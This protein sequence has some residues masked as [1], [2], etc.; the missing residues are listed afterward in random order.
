VNRRQL[1]IGA[2]ATAAAPALSSPAAAQTSSS[3]MARPAQGWVVL[4]IERIAGEVVHVVAEHGGGVAVE[5]KASIELE[6]RLAGLAPGDIV[7]L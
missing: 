1:F 5:F 3:V 2:L 4:W 6:P 7:H